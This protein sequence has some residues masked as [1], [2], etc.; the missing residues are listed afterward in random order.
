MYCICFQ[1]T[2][3]KILD[4]ATCSL[5]TVP[6]CQ[7]L[8]ISLVR[9]AKFSWVT[10]LHRGCVLQLACASQL[11]IRNSPI[12]CHCR[13][14]ARIQTLHST[15]GTSQGTEDSKIATEGGSPLDRRI[16]SKLSSLSPRYVSSASVLSGVT[17][18]PKH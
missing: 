18:L 4:L 1:A 9:G 10:I 2:Y 5:F 16:M 11:D 17:H 12:P 15:V 8:L 14:P 3:Q 6:L 7:P 13:H